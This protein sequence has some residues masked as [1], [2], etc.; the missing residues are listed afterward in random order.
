MLPTFDYC[1]I[2][3]FDANTNTNNKI[4]IP[5]VPKSGTKTCNQRRSVA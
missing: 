1:T 3:R 2:L 5:V 4:S